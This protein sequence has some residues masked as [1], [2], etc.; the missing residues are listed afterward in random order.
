MDD[1]LENF[2]SAKA[3][4]IAVGVFVALTA[5]KLAKAIAKA[6]FA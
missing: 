3:G 6:C 4:E 1:F 5:L 2:N